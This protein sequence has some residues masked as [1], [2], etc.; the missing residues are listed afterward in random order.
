MAAA[1][2]AATVT[3][4]PN[5]GRQVQSNPQ[6]T[7]RPSRRL[8]KRQ[9]EGR[10]SLSQPDESTSAPAAVGSGVDQRPKGDNPGQ[11]VPGPDSIE[12]GF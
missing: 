1:A 2:S 4:A 5:T 11:L 10:E 9:S 7:N 6:R 12:P 3:P 8:R